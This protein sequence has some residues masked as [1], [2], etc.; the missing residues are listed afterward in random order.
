MKEVIH[1]NI[2]YRCVR[3]RGANSSLW[4]GSWDWYNER[5]QRWERVIN[6]NSKIKLNKLMT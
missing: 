6:Y 5:F 4:G 3:P 2:R 1:N